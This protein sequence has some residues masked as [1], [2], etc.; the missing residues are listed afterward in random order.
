LLQ[1]WVVKSEH[2]D[3]R[4]AAVEALAEHYR[5]DAQT[6][7]LLQERAVNDESPVPGG[8]YSYE[9]MFGASSNKLVREV[10][11]NALAEY[12]PDHPDTLSLL[13][14]RAENDPTLWLRERAKELIEKIE[15]E[16]KMISP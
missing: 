13:R 4:G 16:E 6:L 1:E 12:W 9:E 14:E 11:V 7:P 2:F 3:V 15:G 10:A 5:E 8:I